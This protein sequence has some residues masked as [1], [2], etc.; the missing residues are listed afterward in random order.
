MTIKWN[1]PY[2]RCKAKGDNEAIAALNSSCLAAADES[3]GYSR[4]LSQTLHGRHIPYVLL[5]HGG[6]F[7]AEMLSRLLNLYRSRCFQF[8]T[9]PEAERDKFYGEDADLYL[10]PGPDSLEESMTERHLSLPPHAL[11]T[12]SFDTMCC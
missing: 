3:I 12:P 11:A 4:G 6:A 9:L 1:E 7:D 10:S 2:A 8:V 5:M